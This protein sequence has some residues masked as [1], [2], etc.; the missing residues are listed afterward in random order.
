MLEYLTELAETETPITLKS[1]ENS[2]DDL[3]CHVLYYCDSNSF[4]EGINGGW[5]FGRKDSVSMRVYVVP[6]NFKAEYRQKAKPD[7]EVIIV[8][9][10]NRG[11]NKIYFL[12]NKYCEGVRR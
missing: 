8:K 6:Y 12:N 4:I 5:L 1:L 7:D 11:N 10:S 3:N 2:F 9:L